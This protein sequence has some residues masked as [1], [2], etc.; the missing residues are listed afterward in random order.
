MFENSHSNTS[1]PTTDH[2]SSTAPGGI[3]AFR[4]MVGYVIG[5]R[6]QRRIVRAVNP[7]E[8]PGTTLSG[9]RLPSASRIW[10]VIVPVP[11]TWTFSQYFLLSKSANEIGT[12]I[13]VPGAL[14]PW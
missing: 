3:V 13:I 5:L 7:V 12:L 4:R 14:A 11:M 2:S 9:M 1:F 10:M 6:S 8:L